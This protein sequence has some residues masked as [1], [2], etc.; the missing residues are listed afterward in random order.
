[1]Y[2]FIINAFRVSFYHGIEP[3]SFLFRLN[4]I[5]IIN[6]LC[7]LDLVNIQQWVYVINRM[8][9][10]RSKLEIIKSNYLRQSSDTL[11]QINIII[12]LVGFNKRTN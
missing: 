4:E 1:M 5:A 6:L 2:E 8:R 3:R 12:A 10:A 11:F 7:M 9:L